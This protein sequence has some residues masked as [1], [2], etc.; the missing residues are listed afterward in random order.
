MT[1]PTFQVLSSHMGI[2]ATKVDSSSRAL[3]AVPGLVGMGR[4]RYPTMLSRR[5][6]WSQRKAMARRSMQ[7]YSDC[8]SLQQFLLKGDWNG[9]PPCPPH[10]P[11]P[12]DQ[13]FKLHYRICSQA[14]V[15]TLTL[16]IDRCWSMGSYLNS[17]DFCFFICKMDIVTPTAQGCDENPVS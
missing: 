15:W 4:C 17:L 11:F 12:N 1:L 9:A 10:V 8:Q 6:L 7:T 13:C 5:E 14:W 16:L 2:M 3:E